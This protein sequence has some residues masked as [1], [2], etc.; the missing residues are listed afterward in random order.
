MIQYDA[1]NQG[2]D[3]SGLNRVLGNIIGESR[4][5]SLVHNL[6]YIVNRTRDEVKG[7]LTALVNRLQQNNPTFAYAT[8]TDFD[9]SQGTHV[10]ESAKPWEDHIFFSKGKIKI[11][12]TEVRDGKLV[13]SYGHRPVTLDPNATNEGKSE[14]YVTNKLQG[15]TK[16]DAKR[17]AR[18]LRDLM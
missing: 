4:Y 3:I 1:P 6:G 7:T 9:Y 5:N 13:V 8:V 10:P 15:I 18:E 12:G 16:K 17:I 11:R 2:Y 14:G